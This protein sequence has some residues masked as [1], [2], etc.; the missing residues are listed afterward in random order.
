MRAA[1]DEFARAN[2]EGRDAV[3]SD[4]QFH[5]E[6]SR[7]TQN[8]HYV[9]LMSMLGTMMIPRSRLEHRAVP[10]EAQRRYLNGVNAEHERIYTAIAE[11]DSGAARK[12][13]RN[14]LA[15][16]CERRRRAAK[17]S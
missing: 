3:I 9:G 1:L 7:A 16:S 4:Y 13:M 10:D 17:V 5:L 6:I 15:N 8:L 2:E 11:Q 14:H 12:A